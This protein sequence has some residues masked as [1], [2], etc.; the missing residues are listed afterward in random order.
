MTP[1]EGDFLTLLNKFTDD[2]LE[3]ELERRKAPPLPLASEDI[4]LVQL[5]KQAGLYLSTLHT[6]GYTP[7]DAE[8]Y[9]F[10]E[11]MKTFYGPDVFDWINERLR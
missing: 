9:M 11:V 7:K 6:E 1:K 2:E 4:R 8:H 3:E 10:E 5:Q